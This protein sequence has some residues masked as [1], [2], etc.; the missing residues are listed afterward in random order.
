[1]HVAV[2]YYYGRRYGGDKAT[3]LRNADIFVFPTYYDNE[4]FPLVL[5]E[6]M[7]YGLPCIST[8]EGGISDIIED[9]KTGYVIEKL[10]AGEFADKIECLINNMTLRV[11]MG[12]S[13]RK[14]YTERFTLTSFERNFVDCL[15][16]CCV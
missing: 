11:S 10:T 3:F 9:G 6:A 13:G 12:R 7:E 8:N 1:M 14:T 15:D 5:L 2:A 16:K 4:C